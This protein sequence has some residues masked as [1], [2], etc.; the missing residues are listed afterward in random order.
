M[1][2]T[3]E[4]LPPSEEPIVSPMGRLFFCRARNKRYTIEAI[5]ADPNLA[6]VGESVEV[7]EPTNRNW[8][9]TGF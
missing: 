1:T 3:K 9:L 2:A 7:V 5:D 6:L 8:P 4:T